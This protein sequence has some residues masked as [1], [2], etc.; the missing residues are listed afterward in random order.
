MA[1]KDALS[2]FSFIRP[3]RSRESITNVVFTVPAA[4]EL[5]DGGASLILGERAAVFVNPEPENLARV[6]F[7]AADQDALDEVRTLIPETGRDV[8]FDVVGRT[9]RLDELKE[10]L[11]AGGFSH[12][13]RFQRM[14]CKPLPEIKD[15]PELDEVV[16]ADVGDAEEILGITH[17]AFDRMTAHILS[18]EGMR[19]R[20]AAGEVYVVR[21]DGRIAGFSMFDSS[22][23][24]VLLLDHVITRHEYRGQHIAR[25]ILYKKLLSMPGL[26]A[27]IL[28]INE[29]CSGPI[30]YHESNGFRTDGTYDDIYTL[31]PEKKGKDTMD[32]IYEI[33]SQLRPEFDYRTSS[34]FIADGMLNSLDVVSLVSELEGQY[35]ILIDALDIIPE[36]FSTVEGIAEIV[37]K[38]GGTV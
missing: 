23:S 17:E 31:L 11:Q 32:K 12:Y 5:L 16:M 33:L 30:A 27:C 25:R 36:N 21:R 9:E 26:D 13:A 10:I 34:D 7:F 28:W 6:F 35:G 37:R 38:N 2:Y 14:L 15:S 8:V 19:A 3:L 18:V 1:E 24:R 4:Q 29:L 22:A 20:I